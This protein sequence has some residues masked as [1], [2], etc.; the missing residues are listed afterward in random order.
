MLN[1]ITDKDLRDRVEKSVRY[2]LVLFK[3]SDK[4]SDAV[5]REEANRVIVLYVISIIEAIIFFFYE[6]SKEKIMKTEYVNITNLPDTYSDISKPG[7]QLVIATRQEVERK[8][9]QLG[10]VNIVNFFRGKGL[11]LQ[12][13]ADSILELNDISNTFH[14]SKKRSVECTNE[15]VNEAVELLIHTIKHAPNSLKKVKS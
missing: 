13:T 4:N 6:Q 8:T 9:S 2:T 10:L 7:F 1:F 5:H 3:D 12:T 14:L 11:I 15:K